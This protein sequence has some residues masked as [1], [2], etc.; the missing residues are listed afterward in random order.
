MKTK[1]INRRYNKQSDWNGSADTFSV[2][3]QKF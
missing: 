1:K 3:N 2:C